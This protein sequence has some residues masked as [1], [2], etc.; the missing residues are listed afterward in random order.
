MHTFG[1]PVPYRL[2]HSIIQAGFRQG[3]GPCIQT[4]VKPVTQQVSCSAQGTGQI[5]R[6]FIPGTL[7]SV[8]FDYCLAGL[9][10]LKRSDKVPAG[11]EDAGGERAAG[12]PRGRLR[13][14]G[15][16][17]D[18]FGKIWVL[19]LFWVRGAYERF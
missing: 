1:T 3:S 13:V 12:C 11:C 17:R 8:F 5:Q 14:V 2:S 19:I 6:D 9:C 16:G 10:L 18:F 4:A 7:A 15:G